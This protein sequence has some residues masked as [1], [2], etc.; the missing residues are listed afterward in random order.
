MTP[1]I[2]SSSSAP[3]EAK[4]SNLLLIYKRLSPG[5]FC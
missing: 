1:K 4:I 3:L 5:W 2:Q